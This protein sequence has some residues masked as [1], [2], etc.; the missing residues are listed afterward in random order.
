MKRIIFLPSAEL[1]IKESA[2][3]Y[4]EVNVELKDRFVRELSDSFEHIRKNPSAFPKVKN[5][6]RKCLMLDFPFCIYF[7][8]KTESI[9][10]LAVFHTKRNPK[11]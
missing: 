9:F 5:E 4:Y 11:I 10:I 3:F 1:D 6:I 7:V 8:E 2:N